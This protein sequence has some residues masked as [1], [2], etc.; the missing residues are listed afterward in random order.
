MDKY[1]VV[2]PGVFAIEDKTVVG[3]RGPNRPG[4]I[5][6]ENSFTER[7]WDRLKDMNAIELIEEPKEEAGTQKIVP[8]SELD[9]IPKHT[10]PKRS[11]SQA[12]RM[13][14]QL[15]KKAKENAIL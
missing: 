12:R 10:I 14:I 6:M 3:P 1:R 7:Q 15:N 11:K 2:R 5:V 8:K 13:K 9:E 4:Q